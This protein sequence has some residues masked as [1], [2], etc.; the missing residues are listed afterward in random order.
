MVPG[1]GGRV[2]VAQG[3]RGPDAG[4]ALTERPDGGSTSMSKLRTAFA[5]TASAALGHA[6]H[7]AAPAQ[8]AAQPPSSPPPDARVVDAV[9]RH[10]GLHRRPAAAAR[11]R[12]YKIPAQNSRYREFTTE[13]DTN[14]VHPHRPPHRGRRP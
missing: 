6:A 13:L 1:R 14:G 12:P 8:A 4:G 5:A 2:V 9:D 10:A 3:G 11:P 7:A